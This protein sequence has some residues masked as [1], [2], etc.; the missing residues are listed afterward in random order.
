MTIRKIPFTPLT[1]GVWTIHTGVIVLVLGCVVYFSQKV[2]GDVLIS[3]RR[4]V[5]QQPGAEPV[6]MVVTPEN[7]V[8][9]GKPHL[10]HHEYQAK[11]G[12]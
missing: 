12:T 3:R 7:T 6:S 1:A 8:Q 11:L 5:I 10:H 4:V 9:V 2:E